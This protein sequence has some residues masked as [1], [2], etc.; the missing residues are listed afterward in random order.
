MKY[1]KLFQP[2]QVNSVT[3]K[4][5]IIASPTSMSGFDSNGYY[6]EETYNYFRMKAVGGAAM[7]IVG[8]VMVDL[9]NGRSHPVQ[10]GV[11][12][13]AAMIP[14]RNLANAI[15][16]GGA[17]ASVE[18]DH[19]GCLS[20]PEFLH[21]RN[22]K[23]PSSFTDEWGDTCD[24]MTEED[25]LH[26]AD[27]YAEAAAKAKAYGFDMI[28]LHAGHGWL[29]HQFISPL[30]NKRT[31]K[32]GGSLENRLRFLNLVV[33]KVRAAVGARFPIDIRISGAERIEGGYG[34]ETG[35]EIAKAVDGKV[36]LIHVSAG[37]QE[38]P[39]SAIL[40]HP[41]IFQKPGENS[42]LA[43]EIKK[44]VKT[45][46]CTVGA[47]SDPDFMEQYLEETGVDCIA[48]GRQLIA[49]PFFPKKLLRGQA[50]EITPCLRCT[51]CLSG[52][53]HNQ[54]IHCSVNPLIGRED[55]F[56]HP[57]PVNQ[58]GRKVL[59][60]GGGPGGMQAALEADRL[61]HK[62]VLCESTGRLGG[63]LRFA[64]AGG[65]KT[66]MRNYRDSQIAKL[67]RSGVEIHLNTP[68]SQDVV[69]AV[70]P[71]VLIIA[72]GAH[73]FY[74][75]IPGAQGR[76]VVA[77]SDLLGHEQAGKNVVVIGGG[78]VGCEEALQ[79][80]QKGYHVTIVEMQEEL[81]PDCGRMHRLG[82]LHE[83]EQS[84]RI[85]IRTG[86]RCTAITEQAVTA[87]DADGSEFSFPS[88]WVVMAAGMRPNS[89]TAAELRALVPETYVIGDCESAATVLKAVREAHDAVIDLGL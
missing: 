7:V 36:D 88:D 87:V 32:W 74:L 66:L 39:Y 18:L 72:V 35:I 19:G 26:A 52:L 12:D 21:G 68:V 29:I 31:D 22:A 23:G 44:H 57:R 76:N 37:T 6:N 78:L 49:D 43:A 46:V 41:G 71:D 69:D 81:A 89:D 56:F 3:L 25:I 55:Q 24:E 65:F 33:D 70:K 73:P 84:E 45:P 80:A 20:G 27:M 10:C 54:R 50:E 15:H 85:D 58:P 67:L 82:L 42:A 60:A 59:I 79:L 28:M 47:F 51:E 64:D 16:E 86:L 77:G 4:N 61:G 11:D 75:P 8:E 62:V 2:L 63:M 38:V 17:L 48:M 14:L 34:I 9:E 83:V 5:R 53:I 13:P 30:T 40:M 1:E